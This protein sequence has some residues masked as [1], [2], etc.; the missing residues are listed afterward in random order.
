MQDV[1]LGILE[2][3]PA[4]EA[5]VWQHRMVVVRKSNGTPRRTVDLQALNRATMR[6]SHPMTSPYIKA[7]SVPAN[8]YKTVTDAWEGYHSIPLD[9]ESSLMTQFI[10]PFGVFRYKRDPQGYTSSGDAY[11][12]R[13]DEI[14][15]EV[16]DSIRQVDDSL[17]WSGSVAQNFKDT[18]DY[19]TLL[20]R[21]G[22]LQNPAK[23]QFCQK[24]VNWSGFVIG[25]DTVKPMPH[26][27]AAIRSFPTPVNKT[28]MRSFMALMQ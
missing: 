26:L 7:M 19:L 11:N 25:E 18:C 10:T 1:E 15:K 20:G 28:D 4:N 23:F 13:F 24:S 14:T 17:L 6:H 8:T 12:N 2:K 3:V 22:I 21:N 16:K 9:K 5:T 27:T